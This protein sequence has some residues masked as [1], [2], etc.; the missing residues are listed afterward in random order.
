MANN[1][2]SIEME[3][4]TVPASVP[5]PRQNSPSGNFNTNSVGGNRTCARELMFG[6][7]PLS[8]SSKM[9]DTDKTLELRQNHGAKANAECNLKRKYSKTEDVD[10]V[11][12]LPDRTSKVIK[13]VGNAVQNGDGCT[14]YHQNCDKSGKLVFLNSTQAAKH[15]SKAHGSQEKNSQDNSGVVNFHNNT[16]LQADWSLPCFKTVENHVLENTLIVDKEPSRTDENDRCCKS[17]ESSNNESE[18]TNERL[19]GWYVYVT[20]TSSVNSSSLRH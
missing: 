15:C 13:I 2:T 10:V 4:S 9:R 3:K 17:R 12:G 19:N 6:R 11:N 7:A 8:I 16:C 20:G 18:H 1:Y 5:S 14:A